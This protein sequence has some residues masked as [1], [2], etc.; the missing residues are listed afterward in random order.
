MSTEQIE[1]A[2]GA[3]AA[4][5]GV[6]AKELWGV[7]VREY[8]VRGAV[9]ILIGLFFLGLYLTLDIP[10]AHW[11][12]WRALFLVPVMAYAASGLRLVLNPAYHAL[13]NI[14]QVVAALKD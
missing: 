4:N 8:L 10:V 12:S 14:S 11:S 5:L 7:F 3:L 13:T 9:Q 2:L 6:A 1:K